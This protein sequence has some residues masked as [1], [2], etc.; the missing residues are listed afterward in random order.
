MADVVAIGEIL[1]EIM[2]TRTG[3]TFREPGLLTGPYPSGAPAIFADQAAR[4]GAST[5]MV[6]ASARTTS[7]RST[8]SGWRAAGS[9]V[10]GDPARGRCHDRD[11]LR[12]LPRGRRPGLHL[13][14]REL[15][16]GSPGRRAARARAVRGLPLLPRH[17]LV[18]VQR[19]RR[20]RGAAR[21]RAGK[22]RGGQGLVRPERAQGAA[23]AAR[24]SRRRSRR[25]WR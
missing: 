11:R 7:A 2:A 10:R 21:G 12:H 17:G 6:A 9:D 15:G 25:C 19:E 16:G 5:A 8:S 4:V 1:V 3:Q 24:T 14:H 22:G 18:A 13:Q 23:G 20:G